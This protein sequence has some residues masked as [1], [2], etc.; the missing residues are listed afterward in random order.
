MTGSL[1]W[2]L[3]F[4]LLIQGA[5]GCQA[6][7]AS[8]AKGN[9]ARFETPYLLV[10]GVAQD[11]G[12][13][14]AGCTRDCCAPVWAGEEEGHLVSCL[15][16]VDPGTGN[17]WLFDATPDFPAQQHMLEVEH[18]YTMAGIFL[19]HAHIGHYTG[20]MHLGHEVMGA[21]DQVVFAMPHMKAYLEQHGPWSQ[22]VN[23]ENIKLELLQADSAVILT[24][25]IRVTPFRVPHR[26]EY[27]E[28]VG[29]RID[30]PGMTA[31]YIPDIDKWD[32]W[33]KDIST[34]I[35]TVDYA[36]LDGTFFQNGEIAGRDMSEIPHPFI[37][38]SMTLFQS[39]PAEERKKVRF[40]HLNHT[41][42]ALKKGSEAQQLIRDKGFGLAGEGE[43]YGM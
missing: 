4:I 42:P 21:K 23:F 2:A 8:D 41:N 35:Q 33:D 1:L 38:E 17:A 24:P 34:L 3:F 6:P 25:D 39:L 43:R 7:E 5:T 27:S 14:H 36:F 16:M 11:G 12:H 31:L 32:R 9:V 15:A 18:E 29:F 19:T 28:T 22:L 26:D 20:L 10:L 30:G 40:I 37:E 13:P